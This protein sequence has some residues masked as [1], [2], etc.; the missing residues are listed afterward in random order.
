MNTRSIVFE[1]FRNLGILDSKQEN[2][3]NKLQLGSN[4]G[5]HIGRLLVLLGGNDG[6]SNV[7]DE[8]A[9][10]SQSKL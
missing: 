2:L 8:L 9:S 6:K 4:D 3:S 7:L 10:L 5:G 1:N